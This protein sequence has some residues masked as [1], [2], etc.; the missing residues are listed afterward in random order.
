MKT[1]DVCGVEK[2]ESEYFTGSKDGKTWIYRKCK[3]CCMEA[4][5]QYRAI[6]ALPVE[7]RP[8]KVSAGPITSRVCKECGTEKPAVEYRHSKR[9][10]KSWPARTCLDCE[11]AKTSAQREMAPVQRKRHRDRERIRQRELYHEKKD[12]ARAY[13]RKW[14]A[15]N[16]E[17]VYEKNKKYTERNREKANE[18]QRNWRRNNASQARLIGVVSKSRSRAVM[19][20]CEDHFTL[21]EWIFLCGMCQNRCLRCNAEGS[22]S[23][24]H[25]LPFTCGGKNT[26]DNIQPLC[27]TCNT[28]KNNMHIDYR[29]NSEYRGVELSIRIAK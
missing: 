26:I 12:E 2:S 25:I 7:L 4:Q 16:K 28:T 3:A 23:P 27:K 24:D 5:R 20:N 13:N 1:C 18:A 19:F 10:E 8:V 29:P 9:G 11:A 21:S 14:Y 6:K 22:L 17:K 15:A